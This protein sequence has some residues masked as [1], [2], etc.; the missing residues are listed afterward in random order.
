MASLISK[1]VAEID[2]PTECKSK[3]EAVALELAVL[4]GWA[5]K[6]D[7]EA[8]QALFNAVLAATAAPSHIIQCLNQLI[9]GEV[10]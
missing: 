2:P 9:E 10:K 6:S 4:L 1:W 7:S 5:G 3:E 8:G